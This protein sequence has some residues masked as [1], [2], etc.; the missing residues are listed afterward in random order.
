V[1]GLLFLAMAAACV[2]FWLDSARAREM[3]TELAR[4]Q[5]RRYG[6]QFLDGT[7]ALER[8]GVR[9][10]TGGVRVR[11][12]FRFDFSEAGIGR[13]SGR[14]ILVGIELESFNLGGREQAETDAAPPR[15]Y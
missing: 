6:L 4:G 12:T 9:W 13:H 5:C 1:E 11:R 10:T 8:I 2:W 15:W 14:L 7:A 3:A